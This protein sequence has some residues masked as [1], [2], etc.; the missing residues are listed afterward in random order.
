MGQ[1]EMN[2]FE[3]F[4]LWCERHAYLRAEQDY[5]QL[6]ECSR[7]R[8]DRDHG[9]P[10]AVE[11]LAGAYVLN[12]QNQDAVD[13]LT[14]YYM[15]EPDHPL[16]AHAI[17]DALLAMGKR[18]EDFPWKTPPKVLPLTKEVLDV[19][20]AHL[21]PKR[22]PRTPFDLL[23]MFM[24]S[25]YL[26]FSEDDLVEALSVDDRFVVSNDGGLPEISVA[27]KRRKTQNNTSELTSGGRADASP[28]GSS[29]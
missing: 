25:N 19:C 26:L 9:A 7:E 27:R 12:N 2:A 14:P 16:Y 3:R 1:D 13:M 18:V 8:Y 29:T 5:G 4:D 21:K 17:L 28:R 20:Y 6:V 23:F 15:K 10:Q 22:L 24:G 11:A